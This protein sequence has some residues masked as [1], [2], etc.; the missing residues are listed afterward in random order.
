[1]SERMFEFVDG[2]SSKFWA[3]TVTG[4]SHTVR[5]GKIG[6]AGQTKSKTFASDAAAQKDADKLIHEKTG[7][8]YVEKTSDTSPT[9]I[10]KATKPTKAKPEPEPLVAPAPKP[11]DLTVRRVVN[12]E[13]HDWLYATYRP[14]LVMP[15]LPPRAPFDLEECIENMYKAFDKYETNKNFGPYH[16]AISNHPYSDNMSH[17]EAKLWC[18]VLDMVET[19]A[20]LTNIEKALRE[21]DFSQPIPIQQ[22]RNRIGTWS[23]GTHYMSTSVARPLLTPDRFVEFLEAG[24]P[25]NILMDDGAGESI[26]DYIRRTILPYLSD[27]QIESVKAYLR[28]QKLVGTEITTQISGVT[29]GLLFLAAM[30]SMYDEVRSVVDRFPDGFA[31]N[32]SDAQHILWNC[33]YRIMFGLKSEAEVVEEFRRSKTKILPR[34]MLRGWLAHTEWRKLEPIE[35]G[36]LIAYNKDDCK[37]H[38]DILSLVD[39]PETAPVMVNCWLDSKQPMMAKAWLMNHPEQ[40]ILGL[41]P[42]AHGT[43]KLAQ[44]ARSI[45]VELRRKG[46]GPAIESQL[47][48]LSETQAANLREHVLE[49]EADKYPTLAAKEMPPELRE[50]LAKTKTLKPPAWFDMASLPPVVVN[51]ARLSGEDVNKLLSAIRSLKDATMPPVVT[52]VKKHAEQRSLDAFA[53]ALFETWQRE[54][55]PSKEKWAFQTM[56]F[57]G[58]DTSALKITPFIREWPGEGKH[59]TAVVGLN[60]LC[61]I[62][63]DTAL[64]QLNGIAQKV[65]FAGI[66]ANAQKTMET[67]ATARGMTREELEDRIVPDLG[68]DARGGRDFDFGTRKFRMILDSDLSP[69]I[70]EADGKTRADLPKPNA[71]DDAT[72]AQPAS[73]EWK[74]LKKQLKEI[75]K[76]Q[77]PRMEQAMVTMRRWKVAE[78]EPLFVRHPL[79]T[80]FAKRLVWAG[81]DASGKML[82]T[83]RV[84]EELEYTRADD[85]TVNLD[86]FTTIGIVHP[87]QLDHA[88]RAAWGQLFADY[89]ILPPFAQLGRP[90]FALEPGEAKLKEVTRFNKFKVYSG[91]VWGKMEKLLWSRGSSSDHGVVTEFYKFFPAAKVSA[92]IEIT[93]GIARGAL[94]MMSE[95]Q[96]LTRIFFVAGDYRSLGWVMHKPETMLT[97]GEVDP[98]AISEVL[99]EITELTST[100]RG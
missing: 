63:T 20:K 54:G 92:I 19:Q 28:G 94:D 14:K 93:P 13:P 73:E 67:I 39:A 31:V 70:R 47:A 21:A 79:L 72:L 77:G 44:G 52:A 90:T 50:A 87:L 91:A 43:S 75:L 68:L 59:Q 5:Y 82:R 35:A 48:T 98:I 7:K 27:K 3:I 65:K 86:G 2:T 97:W 42:V 36:I 29:R 99:A 37:N 96:S 45:L 22:L 62:G 64:M 84:N 69:V 51:G 1:M 76:I 30:F 58:G 80:N 34:D 55:M 16:W 71:K 12:L 66:K 17:E 89:E 23:P 41:V 40:A 60:V 57:L 10:T 53:W 18:K 8:G 4:E 56:G 74:L 11:L 85:K 15:P 9:P 25:E 38:L 49:D 46:Y 33:G 88:E 81:F 32:K 78:F 6:T 24:L 26:L 100:G 95:E 61:G 83:F